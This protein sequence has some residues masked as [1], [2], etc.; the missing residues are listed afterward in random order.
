MRIVS[1]IYRGR[2]L[3]EFKG[4]DVRPT[5]DM[6]RESLFNILQFRIA[7]KTFLDL[8]SGT[9][10]V[11]I[12]ALSRGAKHVTF[13]DFSRESVALTKKNLEKVGNPQNV[14]VTCRDGGEF[15]KYADQ[16]YDI[17]FLDPPYKSD[18]CAR[19]LATVKDLLCDDG[20]AIF[21]NEK[22]FTEKVEGL[23]KVDE[24]KY[25]RAYITFFEKEK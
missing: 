14:T 18:V 4:N 22:P 25:G 24:R 8:F 21:E 3:A 11:G 16:K 17:I 2:T 5:S 19:A 9:G 1:G 10:A 6:V 15:Y 7:D 13:N 23:V 12:E 20:I